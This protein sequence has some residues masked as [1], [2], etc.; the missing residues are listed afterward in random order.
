MSAIIVA[1]AGSAII[2]GAMSYMGAGEQADAAE[3]AGDLQYAAALKELALQEEMYNQQVALQAPFRD[4]GYE[5]LP[6]LQD[7]AMGGD[8]SVVDRMAP[9][10]R[11]VYNALAL[12][13]DE[14]LTGITEDLNR[15]FAARGVTKSSAAMDRI[16]E[17]LSAE[18]YSRL[19]DQYNMLSGAR[20]DQY[21]RLAQLANIG[22]GGTAQTV[23]AAGDYMSA[24][25]S[26]LGGIGADQANI[27]LLQ[28]DIWGS[29]Y[30]EIGA[31]PTNA[32]N[33]YML[34]S[35]TGAW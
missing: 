34:G 3:A 8:V 19:G 1:I 5:A 33:T 21:N 28:G 11:D 24:A 25:G 27:A 29:A 26:T 22:Q 30:G 17:E 14:P 13:A 20:T 23:G 4:V 7:V 35:Y 9:E 10:Q 6:Q 32:L 18:R 15:Q 31:I 2:G 16:A 12:A